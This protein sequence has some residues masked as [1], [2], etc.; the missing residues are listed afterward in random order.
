MKNIVYIT[1]N[2]INKKQYVG[3]HKTNNIDDNY[4]GS[5]K[6]I[7]KSIKKYGKENFKRKILK[8]CETIEE[9][10]K[11]EETYIKQYNTLNPNGYNISPNG[12]IMLF[13][14]HSTMSKQKISRSLK[15]STY[16]NIYGIKA[17]K[18][19]EKRS[20]ERKGL[21]FSNKWRKNLSLSHKGQIVSEETRK[22]ISKVHKGKFVS[23]E[24]CEKISK[25]KIGNKQI[26]N[27]L[28]SQNKFV[29]SSELEL[30][31]KNGWKTGF[32]KKLKSI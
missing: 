10:R 27:S 16:E 7:V 11:L 6:I 29:K 14:G 28:T 4:L 3:S 24:I 1:T 32:L 18:M 2:L 17:D 9:A 22:K 31:L 8:E 19:K 23:N 21:K 13:T 15:G 30:Y 12:G 25:S 26:H 5:G 20:K